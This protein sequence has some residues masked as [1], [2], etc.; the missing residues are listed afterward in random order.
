MLN[1]LVIVG[2]NL[3][4][5][6]IVRELISSGCTLYCT[7]QVMQR[8]LNSIDYPADIAY[9]NSCDIYISIGKLD[10][11]DMTIIFLENMTKEEREFYTRV[12]GQILREEDLYLD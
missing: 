7:S 10:N 4:S 2:S 8:Y 6:H 3:E 1:R 5:I 9:I 12:G 11:N